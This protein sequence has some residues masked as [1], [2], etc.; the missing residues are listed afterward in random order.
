[1]VCAGAALLLSSRE[2]KELDLSESNTARN[3]QGKTAE[4]DVTQRYTDGIGN[5]TYCQDHSEQVGPSPM[6]SAR[7]SILSLRGDADRG[8]ALFAGSPL[9][10][11]G[12]SPRVRK[13]ETPAR[14][15]DRVLLLGYNGLFA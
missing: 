8:E 11:A 6:V 10:K 9:V 5:V 2:V 1:M 3:V 15:N 13:Q 4:T 7:S 14:P 12:S